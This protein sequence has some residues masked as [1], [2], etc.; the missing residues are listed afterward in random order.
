M[1]M[2]YLGQTFDIHGGGADLVFPHHENELTQS[3]AFTGKP[4]VRYWVHNG[5]ITVDREKMSKSLGNFFTIEEILRKFDPE[6]VR[7][8]LLHTHYRS[9]IEFSDKLLAETEA[10]L[11]RY[12]S[13]LSRINDFLSAEGGNDKAPGAAELDAAVQKARA[14]FAEA[15]DDDFNTAGA[16]GNIFELI[17]ETNKFLDGR[18]SGR[19]ARELVSSAIEAL[20]ELGGVLRLF[21][22][23]PEQW[24]RALLEVKDTGLSPEDIDGM[25]EKRAQARS[26]KDFESADAVRDELASKGVVLEDKPGGATAWRVKAG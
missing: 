9:P 11:D 6:V 7:L 26:D 21:Q 5:F 4:F 14:G 24:Y 8:F 13:T 1:S 15:M 18:P 16:V 25:I 22:R 3:E 23:T 17:H 20:R 2:K 12:Y 19:D 10:S